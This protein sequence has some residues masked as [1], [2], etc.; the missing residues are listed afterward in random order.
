MKITVIVTRPRSRLRRGRTCGCTGPRRGV[1][2]T[3]QQVW[4]SL[5]VHGS[6]HMGHRVPVP[7]RLRNVRVRHV[8]Q[9]QAGRPGRI[10]AGQRPRALSGLLSEPRDRDGEARH[11]ADGA[12]PV[13]RSGRQP[14]VDGLYASSVR[15]GQ[16]QDVGQGKGSTG[17]RRPRHHVLSPWSPRRERAPLPCRTL[18]R[19]QRER[20][21]EVTKVGRRFRYFGCDEEADLSQA[22]LAASICE[23][24]TEFY[25]FSAYKIRTAGRGNQ[26]RRW[27]GTLVR[28]W[29][30]TREV[31]R[32]RLVAR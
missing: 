13:L 6:G 9:F 30:T 11:S 15:H 8:D 23:A 27:L 18:A 19:A 20:R 31:G 4:T 2:R 3:P 24:E 1:N 26:D 12:I 22:R 25:C 16:S 7:R 14:C 10:Q 32:S 28:G 21:R 5:V 29:T 17:A